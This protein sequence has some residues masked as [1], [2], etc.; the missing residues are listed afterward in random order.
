MIEFVLSSQ[1]FIS[2]LSLPYS[3]IIRKTFNSTVGTANL[4]W[5]VYS[6]KNS[7]KT[8]KFSTHRLIIIC[9]TTS[10]TVPLTVEIDSAVRLANFAEDLGPKYLSLACLGASMDGMM[11]FSLNHPTWKKQPTRKFNF[12]WLLSSSK[13]YLPGL[14][15]A[16]ILPIFVSSSA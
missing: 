6:E 11:S 14:Q 4:V 16:N 13:T 15:I 9:R 8:M 1:W 5:W 7:T 10:F 2:C 3:E 12:V